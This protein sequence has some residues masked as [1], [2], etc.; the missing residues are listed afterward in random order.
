MRFL[1]AIL[2]ILIIPMLKYLGKKSTTSE[3]VV[4]AQFDATKLHQVCSAVLRNSPRTKYLDGHYYYDNT[5]FGSFHIS[6]YFD[7]LHRERRGLIERAWRVSLLERGASYLNLVYENHPQLNCLVVHPEDLEEGN[8]FTKDI[9]KLSGGRPPTPLVPLTYVPT[10][11]RI[12]LNPASEP[13]LR[14]A[15]DK[16]QAHLA[17][18]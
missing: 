10:P 18:L 14:E 15:F 2:P 8:F 1:L 7:C 12:I 9:L 16:L 17:S 13:W 5:S 4:M 3:W 11:G 6:N